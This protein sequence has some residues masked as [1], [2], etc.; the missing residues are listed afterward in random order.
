[1]GGDAEQGFCEFP[2]GRNQK[3]L[4]ILR[5]QNNR[6]IL[7]AHTLH[8]VADIFNCRHV[9]QEQIQLINGC[10]RIALKKLPFKL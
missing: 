3:I 7:F 4:D 6:G 1:M 8:S 9:G 5:S 2:N 10:R